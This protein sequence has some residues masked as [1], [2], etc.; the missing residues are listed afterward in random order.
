[1]KNIG[2][3][4]FG[5]WTPSSQS[6]T[7]HRIKRRQQALLVL[8]RQDHMR[9]D[10]ISN[11]SGIAGLIKVRPNLRCAN[12]ADSRVAF[13]PLDSLFDGLMASLG[14]RQFQQL[15]FR[16]VVHLDLEHW[17]LGFEIPRPF[18]RRFKRC[19]DRLHPAID[20]QAKALGH[21]KVCACDVAGSRLV[22]HYQ[23]FFHGISFGC[24]LPI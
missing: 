15:L 8:D 22:R 18:L 3:L 7:H 10:D 14:W 16:G 11:P 24:P 20:F 12:F 13:E 23:R 21:H 1:M 2:F 6:Q 5:H 4:S 19:K 17:K 9:E